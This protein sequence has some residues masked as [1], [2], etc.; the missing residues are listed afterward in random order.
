MNILLHQTFKNIG[1]LLGINK[2][3]QTAEGKIY[4]VIKEDI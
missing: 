4:N 2:F 3:E 1:L